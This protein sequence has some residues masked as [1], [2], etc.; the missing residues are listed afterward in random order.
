MARKSRTFRSLYERGLGKPRW[1][2]K[3]FANFAREGYLMNPWVYAAVTEKQNA[4]A[5][6]RHVLYRV[7]PEGEAQRDVTRDMEAR[8]Q[9]YRSRLRQ[10]ALKRFID[11]ESSHWQAKLGV[12][13]ALSRGI[14]TKML[15]DRGEMEEVTAHPLLDLFSAPN[16][17]YQPDFAAFQ[18]AIVG[19]L[20]LGGMMIMEPNTGGAEG[21]Y[22]GTP[23]HVYVHTIEHWLPLPPKTGNPLPGALFRNDQKNPFPFD[24]DPNKSAFWMMR[25]WHPT[26]PLGGLSPLAAAARSVDINNEGRAWQIALL[27]NSGVSPYAVETEVGLD[28]QDVTLIKAQWREW[29]GGPTN[30][31]DPLMVPYPLQIK[32]LGGKPQDLLW[33]DTMDLSA[34][35]IAVVYNT[36]PEILGDS[37][38]RT[39]SNYQE[40]RKAYYQEN[41]L[42]W[43]DAE[44]AFF[45]ST[46][47][48]RF[49]G[50]KD[51][52]ILAY[53]VDDIEALH[54]EQKALY[55]RVQNA[56]W[57]TVEERRTV[58]GW[59]EKWGEGTM[60]VPAN[61]VPIADL[62][63]PLEDETDD[64]KQ[65]KENGI[66]G[67]YGYGNGR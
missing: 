38:S 15:L 32:E 12:S 52:Y 51:A 66:P 50:D 16:P 30:A 55:E 31:G 7:N 8:S 60:L 13:R 39:Y 24:P 21:D 5:G 35:E 41:I 10:H 64:A 43:M 67:V 25:Y 59:T 44:M 6:I 23:Q 4:V 26:E 9:P 63:T 62:T 48:R 45:G 28:E 22:T 58:T 65:V 49:E 53:D 33:G 40:A 29:N 61:L 1:T 17:W 47:L 18:K 56:W 19:A 37:A 34:R 57:L 11:V 36:P 42:P 2:S 14:V 3:E 27:Q 20:E 54:E 46:L